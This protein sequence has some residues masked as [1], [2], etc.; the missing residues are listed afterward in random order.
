[1]LP[2]EAVI[3][4]PDASSDG[5]DVVYAV[6]QH[7]HINIW[8][9]DYDGSNP[10]QLTGG[11]YD[12][13]PRCSADGKWVV[14][15]SRDGGAAF[16]LMK[17]PIEGGTPVR[18]EQSAWLPAL[19]PDGKWIAYSSQYAPPWNLVVIPF[20]GGPPVKV[21][22]NQG[23]PVQWSADSRAL[24][25]VKTSGGVSNLWSQ[26]LAGGIP[27]QITHFGADWIAD[28]AWSRD[29]RQLAFRRRVTSSN[30]VLINNIR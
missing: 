1:M 2:A 3:G 18:L 23:G 24:T 9:I 15:V 6:N 7:G 26:P 8:R 27:K 19:S 10:L 5:R 13:Q 28:F 16:A 20:E 22:E 25:W 4:W 21:F 14:Y 30:I 29:G 11:N 17:V 12:I